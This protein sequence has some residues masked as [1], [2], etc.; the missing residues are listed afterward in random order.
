MEQM[1]QP[2]HARAAGEDGRVIVA[3]RLRQGRILALTGF[4]VVGAIWTESIRDLGH[5]ILVD[6]DGAAEEEAAGVGEDG[7][8]A[9]GDAAL[10][11]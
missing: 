5:R 9:R 3:L 11:K 8:A 4:V 6:D 1:A 7:G 2:R 10:G